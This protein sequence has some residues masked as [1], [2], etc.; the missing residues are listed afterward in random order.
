MR[1]GVTWASRALLRRWCSIPRPWRRLRHGGGRGPPSASPVAPPPTRPPPP[2][3]RRPRRRRRRSRGQRK[4]GG[5]S[6]G[7]G[8]AEAGQCEARP[9]GDRRTRR[10]LVAARVHH[11]AAR[12]GPQAHAARR[13]DDWPRRRSRRSACRRAGARPAWAAGECVGGPGEELVSSRT[14]IGR[15]QSRSAVK[16]RYSGGD[17]R[18]RGGGWRPPRARVWSRFANNN[19]IAMPRRSTTP[20]KPPPE[21]AARV[22]GYM[23]PA[24]PASTRKSGSLAA[25]GRPSVRRSRPAGQRPTP[26]ARARLRLARSPVRRPSRPTDP[27]PPARRAAAATAAAAALG[28]PR[29]RRRSCRRCSPPRRRS[30]RRAGA[31][32]NTSRRPSASA[33]RIAAP[34]RRA[35]SASASNSA[36]RIPKSTTSA[37]APVR[38]ADDEYGAEW[39][40][41]SGLRLTLFRRTRRRRRPGGLPPLLHQQDARPSMR[42]ASKEGAPRPRCSTCSPPRRRRL[43]RP[44]VPAIRSIHAQACMRS[45]GRWDPLRRARSPALVAVGCVRAARGDHGRAVGAGRQLE[46]KLAAVEEARQGGR[47]AR[48]L[49]M[50]EALLVSKS[51]ADPAAS[52]EGKLVQMYDRF[53]PLSSAVRNS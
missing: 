40:E 46:R 13:Q 24:P 39:D 41:E 45:R 28:Q 29:R 53:R 50:V 37:A 10:L 12:R 21:R 47:A 33:R 35:A 49:D 44:C 36:V 52:V 6:T 38:P 15:R 32:T 42:S 14:S 8:G 26:E 30:L 19:S 48:R 9:G 34:P 11:G 20:R 22:G 5:T 2:I 7:D 43:A 3:R 17:S 1:R 31:A 23:A 18:S 25:L 16:R 4:G 27:A 51:D